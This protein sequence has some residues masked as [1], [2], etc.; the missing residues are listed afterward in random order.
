MK[1]KKYLLSIAGI[2]SIALPLAAISCGEPTSDSEYHKRE[3]EYIQPSER[4]AVIQ[5]N[6]SLTMDLATSEKIKAKK[7]K[8]ALITDT[9]KVT[10]KSF[11]QSAWEALNT[12]ADQTQKSANEQL[13]EFV[14]V[15]PTGDSYDQSYNAAIDNGANV[16]VLPGFTHGDHIKTF[17]KANIEKLRAKKVI[18]IGIDFTLKDVSYENFYALNF[19]VNQASWQLGYA[20]SKYLSVEYP[21]NP[22]SR[23]LASLGG[24]AFFGVTDF[25]TGYLKG[26]KAFND[27][28]S[29]LKTKHA[30]TIDLNA[31][32]KPDNTQTAA[33]TNMLGTEAKIVY[34]VAGP[35][36]LTTV[37]QITKNEKYNDRLV[38]GVDVDQSKALPANKGYF[39]TSVLKNVAQATYDIILAKAFEISE[40]ENKIAHIKQGDTNNFYGGYD[41]GW[42]ALA[43]STIGD[44]AK[45]EV[46]NSAINEAKEKFVALSTDEKA[47]VS[48]PK[49][50]KEDEN[51]N[52]NE[53]KTVVDEL[54]TIVNK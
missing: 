4:V 26:I 13:F 7:L 16:I 8:F 24:G 27:A 40:V 22:E 19:D 3:E 52:Q 29:T 34:P 32:F 37:D 36:T 51:K 42:V 47:F 39:A 45:R 11:N 33:V 41:A 14:A 21:N 10:D 44:T 48:A 30:D 50:K 9:G 18:I 46:M 5:R 53:I 15:E 12:I 25:I 49:A 2:S 1:F 54:I 17:I 20:L 38:V 23:K 6:T 28:N 43:E 35:A 31:G